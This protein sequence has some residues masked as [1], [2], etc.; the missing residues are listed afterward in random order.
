MSKVDE[1]YFKS[2]KDIQCEE[3]DY[4]VIGGGAYGTSFAHRILQLDSEAKILV[5]EKGNYLIPEHIQNLPPTYVK[6]NTEV[7]IRPWQYSGT[8]DLNFMPQIPYLGGRALF[9]NAW[10]PQPDQTEMPN[11]PQEAIEILRPEWYEA[12]C[13]LGRRYSLKTPGNENDALTNVMRN[14]LFAGL[15]TIETATPIGDPSALD[16]AMATGQNVSPE[17]WAKFSPIPVLV[18]DVQA[19]PDRLSVVVNAEVDKLITYGKRVTEIQ[20]KGGSIHVGRATVVLACNTLE[21][22]FLMA[23]SFPKNPL[24]GKNLSGH[25]RSWLAVRVPVD[26]LPG[27]TNGLQAIAF[28]LSGKSPQGRFLHTHISVIHNPHP[29]QTEELLYKILPD[30][31]TPQAVETYKDPKFVVIMLHS[32]GEFLGA[33]KADSWNYVGVDKQGQAVVHVQIQDQDKEFWKVMDTTTYQVAD[34]LAAGAPVEYQHEDGSWHSTPPASIRNKGLVHCAG[35]LWMG[36]DAKNSVTTPRGQVRDV[37][38]LYGAGSMI[39][40]RPGSWNP[41]LTGVTQMF[42]LARHFALKPSTTTA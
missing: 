18:A 10:V 29:D 2:V 40:P 27:L 36:D 24:I 13:F 1:L 3:F 26:S 21:A 9:W 41:T 12:G 20:T 17:E 4:I 28:Y 42:A 8:P 39:F 7:A 32:M 30:A 35:T 22:G 33:P 19:Y 34:V 31:S 14:R 6:L 5:L 37:E 23:R 11:W 38:N 16:C 15:S 25:I